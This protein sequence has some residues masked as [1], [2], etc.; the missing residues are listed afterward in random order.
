MSSPT[1]ASDDLNSPPIVS[2]QEDNG[3]PEKEACVAQSPLTLS[4]GSNPPFNGSGQVSVATKDG[5]A[6]DK[7]TSKD[8]PMV[9][10]D[11]AKLSAATIA[12]K[13]LRIASY[14]VDRVTHQDLISR[15]MDYKNSDIGI[16]NHV[17]I[18]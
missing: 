17:H 11:S 8:V 15:F 13:E 7:I 6:E 5:S 1:T 12:T 10:E 4:D 3:A 14:E 9:V 18:I 2:Q 16:N